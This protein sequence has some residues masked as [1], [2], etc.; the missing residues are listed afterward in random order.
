MITLNR[1][2]QNTIVDFHINQVLKDLNIEA[3]ASK[4]KIGTDYK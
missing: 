1:Q 4:K 3:E 2:V